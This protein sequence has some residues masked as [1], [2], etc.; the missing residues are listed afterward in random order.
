MKILFINR[1][2]GIAW[3]GGENYD[4][5]LASGLRSL[6]HQVTFLTGCRKGDKPPEIG[7]ETL[8]VETPYLRHYM[9]RFGGKV[10]L[11]PGAVAET[12][13]H[14]FGAAV[15]RRLSRMA[16]AFDVAQVLAL[17]RLARKLARRGWRVAMRFPGPPAWFQSPLLRRLA[18]GDRMPMFSH[19]DA[20]GYFRD[21]LGIPVTEVLPG[22]NGDLYR[23]LAGEERAL[24]RRQIGF[25]PDDFVLATVGR[26]VP[27]KGHAFL[28]DAIGGIQDRSRLRLLVAGDGP[29]R[30]SLE[31]R[32]EALGLGRTVHFAGQQE[33]ES[34][35]RLLAAS[36]AFCLC[37]DYENYSNAVLEA[38]ATGL[39]VLATRVGG[40]PLQVEAGVNGFL[41][42]PGDQVSF[43]E[44]VAELARE[45]E[46][47]SRLGEGA[48]RF[49]A[50][51]SWQSS[52]EKVTR[53]YE[54]LLA[55]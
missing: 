38:M 41:V 49:A 32:S 3:G 20:V 6:G 50:R 8:S 13:L 5:N 23:P 43:R 33:R 24:I 44:R 1:M 18:L 21:R 14:L 46:L 26:L 52:A 29:L 27:G 48:R 16:R 25:G 30:G 10:P 39:P 2:L 45:P 37:S 22:V 12:D 31:A 17:P 35:A 47:T 40:F 28:L 42:D 19:G 11:V 15:M 51:M 53:I 9:Y 4:Y 55:A 7:M 54:Q 34:V 36:D